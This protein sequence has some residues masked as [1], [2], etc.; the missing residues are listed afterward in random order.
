MECLD[1]LVYGVSVKKQVLHRFRSIS[2]PRLLTETPT[3]LAA[4]PQV[5]GASVCVGLRWSRENRCE[6]QHRREG[7]QQYTIPYSK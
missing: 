3:V 2:R 1:T 5:N 7:T 4:R 6:K